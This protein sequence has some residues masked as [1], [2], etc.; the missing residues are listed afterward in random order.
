MSLDPTAAYRI[1][2]ERLGID[3]KS[4][5][6]AAELATLGVDSLTLL[7]LMF[8]IEEKL[9]VDIGEDTPPPKTCG[10]LSQLIERVAAGKSAVDGA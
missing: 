4:A 5:D 6:P 2:E 3:L 8:E 9:G 1:I 7:E 10:E